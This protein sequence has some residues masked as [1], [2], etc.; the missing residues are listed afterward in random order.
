MAIL[1]IARMGH[2]VLKRVAQPIDD[3]GAPEVRRLVNDMLDTLEDAGGTGL[4]APQ[5]HVP[6]RL[7]LFYVSTERA[8]RENGRED[9]EDGEDAPDEAEE[10]PLTVLVNPTLEPLSEEM[11]VSWEACLSL[12][13]LA[14]R[15]P[16]Y[17]AV[18]Y[19][20]LDLRGEEI[21]REARGFHARVVQHECDHL[22][23]VLYP[24]RMTDL[25][26][27]TFASELRARAGVEVA[28][29]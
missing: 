22:D 28:E 27:L 9:G 12:P 21:V 29:E 25:S 17:K 26:T 11:V 7:V 2:P 16:R 8:Q 4:A 18:R 14:G 3:P 5:V 10:V 1:K 20:G 24:Q 13:D 15:V 19:R 6:R 23:G